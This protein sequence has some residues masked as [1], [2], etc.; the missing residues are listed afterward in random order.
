MLDL[1]PHHY[2][3]SIMRLD[4]HDCGKYNKVLNHRSRISSNLNV[5][6]TFSL[7][8]EVQGTAPTNKYFQ[9]MHSAHTELVKIWLFYSQV[10][11]WIKNT[12][13]FNILNIFL[14][15]CELSLGIDSLFYRWRR[16]KKKNWYWY[17][18]PGSHKQWQSQNNFNPLP[19]ILVHSHYWVT[20]AYSKVVLNY[21]LNLKQQKLEV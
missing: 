5:T 14:K 12:Y 9:S 18:G 11:V 15:I 3:T 19:P 20:V 16:R 4:Q 6:I 10:S 7:T 2:F 8:T 13:F 21:S 1:P 17:H